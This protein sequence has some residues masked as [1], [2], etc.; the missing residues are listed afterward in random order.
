M[1]RE[2]QEVLVTKEEKD[3]QK[4]K[5]EDIQKQQEKQ[6]RWFYWIQVVFYL[7]LAT[8]TVTYVKVSYIK[9]VN[10]F[11]VPAFFALNLTMMIAVSVMYFLIQ[12]A[13]SLFP[14]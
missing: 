14:N 9:T 6:N 11:F 3:E 5:M 1:Q 8:S 4:K 2:S 13:S 12:D 10:Y 7:M